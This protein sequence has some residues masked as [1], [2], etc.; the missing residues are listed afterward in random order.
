MKINKA[1]LQ[2]ALEIVKPG[3]ASTEIIEQANAFAFTGDSITTYND[4]ISISHPLKGL[5]EDV[6]GAVKAEELYQFLNKTS[7]EEIEL[8]ATENEIQIKAG[9]GKAGLTFQQ[10]VVLPLE[11]I[12][13]IKGWK[14]LPEKFTE[15][16][17]F[18]RSTC[19]RNQSFPVLTCIHI[20]EDGW[21]ES[22][23]NFRLTR[24]QT[25]ATPYAP[26]LIPA[27]AVQELLKLEEPPSRIAQ[28]PGWVHFK[29]KAG[30]VFSCRIFADTF[31][32]TD[33]LTKVKGDNMSFP[34]AI[35]EIV[36]RAAV[37]S[38]DVLSPKSNPRIQAT[39]TEGTLTIRGE[40]VSGWFEESARVRYKGKDLTFE[41]SPMFLQEA[42]RDLKN[43]V[44]S[45]DRMLF[46]GDNWIHV[47]ALVEPDK[48]ETEK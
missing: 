1:D 29:T 15:A 32:D 41:I 19:S 44:I 40:G 17:D 31:P 13:E 23:D 9:K 28:T 27:S 25:E 21:V 22:T 43:C 4:E 35:N 6:K 48:N 7:A 3:I 8:N 11:E 38:K 18:V 14:K 46:S 5:M 12:G 2:E 30:T 26:I 47:V 42:L 10:E 20:R 33:A 34:K 16:L 39:L 37:F 36:D 45:N 24:Y